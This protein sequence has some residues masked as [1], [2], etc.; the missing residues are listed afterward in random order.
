MMLKFLLTTFTFLSL[1]FS[2]TSAPLETRIVQGYVN[3]N[4]VSF[5]VMMHQQ[6]KPILHLTESENEHLTEKK[7]VLTNEDFCYQK[8]CAIKIT[9]NNLKANTNYTLHLYEAGLIKKTL[10][11]NTKNE[12]NKT[13]DFSI[14]TG[15][16][17]FTPIGWGKLLFPFLSLNIYKEM[18][19]MQADF[20]LWLGD[21]VYYL[22]DGT[23]NRK[24]RRHILYRQRDQLID[25]LT[26][27]P[28]IAMWDDHDFGNNNADGDYVDKAASLAVFNQFWPNPKS[29]EESG[30]YFKI[31]HH[32]VDFFILDNRSYSNKSTN[33]TPSILGSKQKK[34]LK[35]ALKNSKAN[36]KII[37]S[38]NQF[39]AD[40]LSDKTFA[41]YPNERQEIFDFLKTNQIEGVFF[42]TGDRHHTEI[43]KREVDGLYSMYEYSCSPVTSWPNAKLNSLRFNKKQRMK[44]TLLNK[45][46]FGKLSFA[47]DNANRICIIETFNKKGKLEHTFEIKAKNLCF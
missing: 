46:N 47:G 7:E 33:V 4:S 10:N 38:G 44:G 39:I 17:S 29:E 25:F 21:T 8:S 42:L 19:K 23:Q 12:N 36:F 3:H 22:N 9:F 27:I 30:I 24:V 26:A 11:F 31:S 5:S 41:L 43:L 1:Y 28:Q 2:I 40:Y 32:D 16:C 13:N 35:E 14:I 6:V 45:R 15:S 18:K 37:C 34:W 20:M